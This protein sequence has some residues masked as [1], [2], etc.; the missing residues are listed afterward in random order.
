MAG[1]WEDF[2]RVNPRIQDGIYLGSFPVALKIL[3]EWKQKEEG[4]VVNELLWE[5]DPA[6]RARIQERC[7]QLFPPSLDGLCLNSECFLPDFT[8]AIGSL[9][10]EGWTV[11]WLCD[12]FWGDSKDRDKVVSITRCPMRRS[13]TPVHV[14]WRRFTIHWAR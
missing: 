4:R 3:A 7:K 8:K 1:A 11:I 9:S 2:E 6:V 13:R 10:K 14:R 12:P 5:K